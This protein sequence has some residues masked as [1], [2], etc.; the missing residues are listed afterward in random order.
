MR[1]SWQWIAAGFLAGA[2]LLALLSCT[3][4]LVTIHVHQ[5]P[6]QGAA[7]S[8]PSK[9]FMERVLEDLR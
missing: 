4:P 7:T 3:I 6:K 2:L 9:S 1:R 8:Q 5:E